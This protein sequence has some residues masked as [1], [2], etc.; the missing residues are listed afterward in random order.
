MCAT[1]DTAN[2]PADGRRPLAAAFEMYPEPPLAELSVTHRVWVHGRPVVV[3]RY[4]GVSYARFATGSSAPVEV[5]V[6]SPIRT[7]TVFPAE[8]VASSRV[9]GTVLAFDLPTPASVV[10]WI[11]QLAPLFLLPDA[12]EDDAPV[13]G[14]PHVL[15][16]TDFGADPNGRSS[17]TSAL[18][19]AINRATGLSGGGT[20]VLPRGVYRSGTLVLRSNVSLY[21]APGA[22]LQ[23]SSDPHDYPIDPGRH[24]SAAD[25]SLSPDARY[26]GRTMTFSRLLLVDRATNVRISGRGTI[27]GAGRLLRTQHGIAPNLLRVR[28]STQVS[29]RDVLFRNAAAWSLH[30]LASSGVTFENIKVIN[31]RTM[32]NTDGI[33]V[34]M[35]SDVRIDGSFIYTKDD[36][37]CVKATRNSDLSG[38]PARILAT[39]NLVSARDAAL[40]VGSESEAASFSDIRFER[41]YVFDSGRA[42]SIVVRDGATYERVTY[43]AIEVGPHVDHLIEQVIG[44]RDP[45]A[46]LGVIRDLTFDDVSAPSFVRPSSNWTW[47]AQFRPARPGPGT[48]MPVFE[49][50]DEAHPVEGLTLKHVVVNGQHLHDA[51]AARRVANLSVGPHVRDVTFE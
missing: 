47:Y 25:A 37:I 5:Q 50:A 4:A 17:A 34:D 35:S 10:V 49:G 27:D 51:A 21:L 7:H 43:R 42:M 16:V 15:D 29:V 40:K 8:R 19:A 22:L 45:T 32:L 36:A 9:G 18:Q 48:A 13:H 41:D 23:G 31:D 3:Q 2:I 33:D 30:V 14:L 11:D 12:M 6:T 46:A 1:K 26:H 39:D 28:E 24:E 38:N 44:V 20:V